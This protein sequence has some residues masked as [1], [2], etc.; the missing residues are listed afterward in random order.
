MFHNQY[1]KNLF[2]NIYYLDNSNMQN[3]KIDDM[4]KLKNDLSKTSL[5]KNKTFIIMD[6]VESFNQKSLNAILK[7]IEEPGTNNHF[8]DI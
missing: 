1:T 2:P 5:N 8:F 7:I 3:I 4:R 6:N